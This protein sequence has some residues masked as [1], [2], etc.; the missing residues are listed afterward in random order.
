MRLVDIDVS[1]ERAFFTCLHL[2]RPEELV[3]TG[4]RR[5]W[6]AYYGD[7][8]YRAQVL[9][10]DDGTAVGKLHSIPIE[11]SPFVGRDLLAILCLYVHM[12]D[13]HIGDQR[14]QNYGRFMLETVESEARAAGWK[15]I[16][17]WAMDW[18]VWNPVSFYERMGFARADQEGK[19]VAI[20]KP[21][22]E[23]A[24]APRLLRLEGK[25]LRPAGEKVRVLVADNAWCSS[26][27]KRRTAREAV[28]GIEEMVEYVEVGKP[29]AGRILHLGSIGG[30]FLDGQP[31]RPY[32]L[33]G[34]SS[35]LRG[36][37]VRLYEEKRR[38]R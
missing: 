18:D 8:G 20:W 35:E 32:G 1:T 22:C 28:A 9:Q 5:A 12:Y 26:F 4:P 14:R 36:E 19:V 34:P 24:E 3:V 23:E 31:Y 30:V 6:H 17:A 10:L 25:L 16:V 7:R 11:H 13:H 29:W 15:G 37:I 38:E 33:I 21:F 2:E 27:D